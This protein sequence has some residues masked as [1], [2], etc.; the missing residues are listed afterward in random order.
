MV[1][2]AEYPD[3]RKC[4]SCGN[5]ITD[6]G[7]KYCPNCRS[8]ANKKKKAQT[9]KL[10]YFA[11]PRKVMDQQKVR[12]N[13]NRARFNNIRN[14]YRTVNPR[15]IYDVMKQ[16]AKRRGIAV[17]ISRTEFI[18]WYNIQERKCCYCGRDEK[19]ILESRFLAF[20]TKDP[21]SISLTP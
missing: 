8:V 21:S 17:D 19:T 9:S 5:D 12:R 3:K 1:K 18:E 20:S 15:G 4:I 7:L 13:K 16:G 10:R 11:D 6:G 14:L 2:M